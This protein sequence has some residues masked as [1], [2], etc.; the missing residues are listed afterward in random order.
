MIDRPVA[1]IASGVERATIVLRASVPSAARSEANVGPRAIARIFH[2]DASGS[3]GPLETIVRVLLIGSAEPVGPR[4][5]PI[6][7]QAVAI[8][9]SAALKTIVRGA[10]TASAGRIGR[11]VGPRAIGPSDSLAATGRQNGRAWVT[12]IAS[13]PVEKAR[14][15]IETA[16]GDLEL[17]AEI[18]VLPRRVPKASVPIVHPAEVA[19]A[20]VRVLSEQEVR[21]EPSALLGDPAATVRRAD[22]VVA[23]LGVGRDEVPLVAVVAKACPAVACAPSVR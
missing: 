23:R 9:S 22:P 6:V 11:K 13:V 15:A 8:D 7:R 3:S 21:D 1:E 18:D 20:V 19:I 10:S 2:P 17:R 16:L 5:A 14:L 4:V 12:V